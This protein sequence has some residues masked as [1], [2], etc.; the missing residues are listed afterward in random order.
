MPTM[1]VLA[2][3][4]AQATATIITASVFAVAAYVYNKLRET[5]ITRNAHLPQLRPSWFWGHMLL[6][7]KF[8]KRGVID[9]HPGKPSNFPPLPQPGCSI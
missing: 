9:R 8:T 6:F 1:A 2:F 3:G 5:R 4:F 7:D